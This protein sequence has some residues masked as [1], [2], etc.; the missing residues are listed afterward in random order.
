MQLFWATLLPWRLCRTGRCAR[1]QAFQLT[2]IRTARCGWWCTIPK[3]RSRVLWCFLAGG[4][5]A[6]KEW[7][8]CLRRHSR[9]QSLDSVGLLLSNGGWRGSWHCLSGEHLL[10]ILFSRPESRKTA[11]AG[12]FESCG[13]QPIMLKITAWPGRTMDLRVATATSKATATQSRIV[14]R[15]WQFTRGS[16]HSGRWDCAGE[17]SRAVVVLEEGGYSEAFLQAGSNS[18]GFSYLNTA[19]IATQISDAVTSYTIQQ[20]KHT[21]LSNGRSRIRTLSILYGSKASI[22]T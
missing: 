5:E 14:L 11:C 10:C 6:R 13:C 17:R 15:A 21:A 4:G 1:A 8:F 16:G 20:N 22:Y 2:K 7:S 3:F 9:S 18:S 19:S 12:S